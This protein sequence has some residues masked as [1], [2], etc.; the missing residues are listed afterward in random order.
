MATPLYTYNT[1]KRSVSAALTRTAR[2]DAHWWHAGNLER[3]ERFKPP[4]AHAADA[5][6][7][8]A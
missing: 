3:E 7:T 4:T 6:H 1:R 8:G 5:V 2:Q